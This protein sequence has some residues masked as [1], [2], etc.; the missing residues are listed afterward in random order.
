ML[1]D[2]KYRQARNIIKAARISDRGKEMLFCAV[3]NYR[4][5]SIPET[6]LFQRKEGKTV[7]ACLV[8]AAIADKMGGF[9]SENEAELTEWEAKAS[10]EFGIKEESIQNLIC[11]FDNATSDEF[12]SYKNSSYAQV[13]KKLSTLL[14]VQ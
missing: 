2:Y 8:G 1:T 7:K 10:H 11:G 9:M 5:K 12:D 13:G 6:G 4:T 3:R 14:V